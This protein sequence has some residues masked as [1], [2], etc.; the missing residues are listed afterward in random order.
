MLILSFPTWELQYM[1]NNMQII[2]K[3]TMQRR[4][5][6]SE[7]DNPCHYDF[8]ATIPQILVWVT[9]KKE[10]CA[11]PGGTKG[12]PIMLSITIV[13]SGWMK[14]NE[15]L[16]I[17]AASSWDQMIL[18]LE[19]DL[20]VPKQLAHSSTGNENKSKQASSRSETAT[21]SGSSHLR[22]SRMCGSVGCIQL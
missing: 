18:I 21:T 3:H 14:R 11:M 19:V 9:R 16:S 15:N 12:N 20:A 5:P 4:W 1:L 13:K 7:D 22:T 10:S 17:E 2:K 6:Q 8:W